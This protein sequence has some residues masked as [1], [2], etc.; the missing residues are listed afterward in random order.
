LYAG[1]NNQT[2]IVQPSDL[3]EPLQQKRNNKVKNSQ[4]WYARLSDEKKGAYLEKLR[5]TRQQKKAAAISPNINTL[6]R[7][8]P[9]FFTGMAKNNLT[10]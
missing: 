6:V 7:S 10:T 5:I 3:H 9:M 2:G 4:S 1:D 8:S